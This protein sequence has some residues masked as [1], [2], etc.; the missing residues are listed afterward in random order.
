MGTTRYYSLAF[1]DFGDQLDSPLNVNKEIDRFVLIDKQLYGLYS[2]FGNGVIN[3]WTISD[4]GFSQEEGISVNISNGLGII[5]FIASQTDVPGRIISLPPNTTSYIYAVSTGNTTRTRVVNFNRFNQLTAGP[6]AILLAK[7]V[8]SSNAVSVI[9]NTIR[10]QISFE[11]VIQEK[12]D[13]HK[14][15][16]TPTKIDLQEEIK[17]QLPGAR[18]ES[19]DASKITSGVLNSG[20]IPLVDHND[21]ENKGLMTHAALDSFVRS[22]SQNN[23]ELLGEIS[24]VNLLKTAIFLKYMYS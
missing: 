5:N 16:G 19:L 24:T 12:I 13:E 1:F 15:R 18:I 21:L 11:E 22:L 10:E 3:G 4:G 6:N 7:V 8:T 2:I 20:T 14:H 23:K 17:N 9:D